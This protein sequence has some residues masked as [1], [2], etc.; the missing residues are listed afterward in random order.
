MYIVPPCV[1]GYK[2]C[3]SPGFRKAHAGSSNVT[4]VA[5][6]TGRIS[7]GNGKLAEFFGQFNGGWIDHFVVSTNQRKRFLIEPRYYCAFRSRR[8]AWIYGLR[9]G[10]A[11]RHNCWFSWFS[12]EAWRRFAMLKSLRDRLNEK[13]FPL[14][15]VKGCL[16]GQ[17]CK[18]L[19][20]YP[21]F[22]STWYNYSWSSAWIRFLMAATVPS[23]GG[24]RADERRTSDDFR[25]SLY[26]RHMDEMPEVICKLARRPSDD[27]RLFPLPQCY[28]KMNWLFCILWKNWLGLAW[29]RNRT[30]MFIIRTPLNIYK[31][32]FFRMLS[33]LHTW[34]NRTRNNNF[35]DA[36]LFKIS[37]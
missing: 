6:F 28:A 21:L 37:C 7:V 24:K 31:L 35:E 2:R 27:N 16:G 32:K 1:W 30:S 4:M 8:C 14:T 34:Q 3:S 5:I 20:P 11:T 15:Q 26:I 18:W 22:L 9:F 29:L 33:N 36:I 13:G 10:F 23:A 17:R 25:R 12:H 19:N